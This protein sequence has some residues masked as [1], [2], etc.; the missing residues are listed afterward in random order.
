MRGEI[1]IISDKMLVL[2]ECGSS[3]VEYK[4]DLINNSL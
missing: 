2:G 1:S 3:N 4:D